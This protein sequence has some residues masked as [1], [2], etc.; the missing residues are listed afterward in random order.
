MFRVEIQKCRK[1]LWYTNTFSRVSS[2]T[3]LT[4]RAWAGP[5]GRKS[6]ITHGDKVSGGNFRE[7]CLDAHL[8]EARLRKKRHKPMASIRQDLLVYETFS[9]VLLIFALLFACFKFPILNPECLMS[10]CAH[11]VYSGTAYIFAHEYP[12]F[13]LSLTRKSR[14]SFTWQSWPGQQ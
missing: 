10:L 12:V 3:T 11:S 9:I 6:L 2:M 5:L 13:V 8:S 14:S 1:R 7:P 4:E